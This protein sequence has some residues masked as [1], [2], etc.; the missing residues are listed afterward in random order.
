MDGLG[1][2]SFADKDEFYT[3]R[4]AIRAEGRFGS[5]INIEKK[6]RKKRRSK[7]EDKVQDKGIATGTVAPRLKEEVGE[8]WVP[9]P[10]PSP[11]TCEKPLPMLPRRFLRMDAVCSMNR[12]LLRTEARGVEGEGEP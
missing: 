6:G 3:D 4:K 11:Q 2:F 7:I 1:E 10:F 5:Y 9:L 8:F 12:K